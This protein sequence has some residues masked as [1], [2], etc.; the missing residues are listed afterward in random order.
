MNNLS[1]TNEKVFNVKPMGSGCR[2]GVKFS[3]KKQ[4]GTYTKGSFLNC[5]Y[6]NGVL[7]NG[8]F[9]NLNGWITDNEYNDR[10]TL[11]FVVK[12]AELNG[13]RSQS[14][15]APKAQSMPSNNM[16]EIDINDEEIPF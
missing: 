12:E 10:N 6:R 7:E 1:L 11:E 9:Y 16:P 13:N 2:F 14:Q 15:Q 3:S 8:G 4:D 5:V